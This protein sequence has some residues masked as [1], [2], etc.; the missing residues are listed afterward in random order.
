MNWD[1]RIKGVVWFVLFAFVFWF[2]GYLDPAKAEIISSW[3]PT[4]NLP[5]ILNGQFSF[6]FQNNVYVVG[7]SGY[8]YGMRSD[9][10]VATPSAEGQINE[11]SLSNI[12]FPKPTLWSTYA[13]DSNY[14]YSIGGFEEYENGPVASFNN[15]YAAYLDSQNG[16]SHWNERT[17]FTSPVSQASAAILNNKIYI[18]GGFNGNYSNYIF[19]NIVYRSDIIGSAVGPWVQVAS[20]PTPLLSHYMFAMGNYLYIVGGRDNSFSLLDSVYRARVDD[21]G[22][23]SSWE[24][25]APLPS[26]AL[27]FQ[28]VTIGR[29]VF[30][31]SG[32][33]TYYAKVESD[34]RITKWNISDIMLPHPTCCGSLT[35][36][37]NYLYL[38]GGYDASDSNYT[39]KVYV[40]KVSL[41]EE[42]TPTPSPHL[43]HEPVILVPGMLASFNYL[44]LMHGVP[45]PNSGWGWCP[46]YCKPLYNG[47]ISAL[48]NSGYKL[49]KDLF[50]YFYDWRKEIASNADDLAKFVD[51]VL[52]E[53]PEAQKIS[54]VGH[55][56]G[57][58]I[59]RDYVQDTHGEKIDKLITVG[60][61]HSG[62]VKAYR[63]WEAANFADFPGPVGAVMQAVVVA[64]M[65]HYTTDVNTVQKTVPS[66][67]NL[68]PT[69]D[70]IK[71]ASGEAVPL[72]Q[73]KFKNSY[74]PAMADGLPG[75]SNRLWTI[76][77]SGWG[78]ARFLTVKPTTWLERNL[79]WWADGISVSTE[80]ADGD[81]TVLVTSSQVNGSVENYNI[82]NVRHIGLLNN[83]DVQDKLLT[84]LGVQGEP[85]VEPV[86]ESDKVLVVTVASPIDFEL[87]DPSGVK[88]VPEDNIILLTD[89][90][91]GVW[92]VNTV[93]QETGNY[94]VYFGRIKGADKAWEEKW[95]MATE[96]SENSFIF[97]V[98][99]DERNLGE[100]VLE[101]A[102]NRLGYMKEAATTSGL[103]KG[104]ESLLEAQ[105]KTYQIDLENLMGTCSDQRSRYEALMRVLME[106]ADRLTS[107][108]KSD[109]WAELP[110]TTEQILVGQMQ[111]LKYDMIQDYQDKF[112]DQ[113]S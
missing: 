64:N 98:D 82:N 68:W 92:R 42:V 3:T 99:M 54:L 44:S 59:A 25:Q 13:I 40:T 85:V 55:S 81:E 111:K 101:Q 66:L 48:E 22:N 91:A 51:K 30:I 26:P 24:V 2:A 36:M 12:K 84:V 78:T 90:V 16:I 108:W 69:F 113:N 72:T 39:D 50:V 4:K 1:I 80:T 109:L 110:E 103:A 97:N 87:V 88:Y 33:D 106:R 37:G 29:Y 77:G 45:V 89:P 76:S 56:M 41:P 17:A 20:L 95:G 61:P 93:G 15:V 27:A 74:L 96:G 71:N 73:M 67:L 31:V 60:S 47:F 10:L 86:T 21:S 63:V 7:G 9:I 32:R 102:T 6:P 112:V 8:L 62:S 38:V 75:I 46:V 107:D 79:G 14:V 34:G 65:S 18:S 52:K 49:G 105:L 43:S 70:F 28:G 5:F 94:T 58:L 35:A 19:S 53:N 83:A 23:L 100:N 104:R 57:G 11:W